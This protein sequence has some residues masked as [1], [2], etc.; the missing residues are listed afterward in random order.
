MIIIKYISNIFQLIKQF[1]I[2]IDSTTNDLSDSSVC[3][4]SISASSSSLSYEESQAV[5]AASHQHSKSKS[6]T[7]CEKM[8]WSYADNRSESH[9][10]V[11]HDKLLTSFLKKSSNSNRKLPPIT[12]NGVAHKNRNSV[13]E[14]PSLSKHKPKANCKLPSSVKGNQTRTL[15]D[16][17]NTDSA[18]KVPLKTTDLTHIEIESKNQQQRK[19]PGN[20]SNP[21]PSTSKDVRNK[22]KNL[23]PKRKSRSTSSLVT[24]GTQG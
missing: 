16:F 19:K 9:E 14:L 20:N 8:F 17:Y 5:L 10:P 12:Q 11:A 13:S 22:Q 3:D 23:V 4:N 2:N 21:V 7:E 1:P 6:C 15:P 18:N 24:S